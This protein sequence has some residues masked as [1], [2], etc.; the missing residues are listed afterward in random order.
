M[1]TFDSEEYDSLTFLPYVYI[2]EC[3]QID[4]TEGNECVVVESGF[5]VFYVGEGDAND[6]FE[7]SF[8]DSIKQEIND[9]SLVDSN[10]QIVQIKHANQ[11][12][13]ASQQQGSADPDKQTEGT[14][15]ESSGNALPIIIGALAG[16]LLIGAAVVAYRRSKRNNANTSNGN[17][18]A[19]EDSPHGPEDK[20]KGEIE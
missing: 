15:V 19:P 3:Q 13:Y 4:S 16:T 6:K 5:K 18:G 10:S 20:D 14:V 1:F 12:D 11:D 17:D 7:E 2:V 9:N 8:Q